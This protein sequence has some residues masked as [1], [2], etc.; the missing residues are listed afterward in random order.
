MALSLLSNKRS[1]GAGPS[2]RVQA[3]GHVAVEGGG[4]VCVCVRLGPGFFEAAFH[5]VPAQA[6]CKQG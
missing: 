3:G 1:I 5:P 4:V 2:A 6:W